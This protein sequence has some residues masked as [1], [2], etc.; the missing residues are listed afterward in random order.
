MDLRKNGSGAY[1]PTAYKAI[2]NVMQ[3]EKRVNFYKG[4][5]IEV[6]MG[7]GYAEMAVLQTHEQ[8]ATVLRLCENKKL[9]LA[10]NCKGL[11]YADP[12][13]IQYIYNSRVTTLIRSMTGEEYEQMMDAVINDLGWGS[14]AEEHSGPAT[15]NAPWALGPNGPEKQEEPK[16]TQETQQNDELLEKMAKLGNA[17]IKAEAKAEAYKQMYEELLNRVLSK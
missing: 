7:E 2:K 8:Y 16:P 17:A 12:G 13:M 10:I 3:E 1:D 9:P 15:V 4:D 5:I 14:R 11:K 6:E